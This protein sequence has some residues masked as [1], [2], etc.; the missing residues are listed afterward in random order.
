MIDIKNNVY[1]YKYNIARNV[2][3]QISVSI[4][5]KYCLSTTF[6]I[7]RLADNQSVYNQNVYRVRLVECIVL[8]KRKLL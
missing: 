3:R 7:P 6:F 2:N 1:A 4:L 8:T 5:L